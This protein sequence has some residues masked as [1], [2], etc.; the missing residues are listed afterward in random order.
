MKLKTSIIAVILPVCISIF[1][2]CDHTLGYTLDVDDID[3]KYRVSVIQSENGSIR[4]V[5]AEGIAGTAITLAINP[6]P[7]YVLKVGSLAGYEL[8]TDRALPTEPVYRFNLNADIRVH[9]EFVEA[10]ANNFT[11]SVDETI[12]NGVIIAYAI[13]SDMVGADALQ[14]PSGRVNTKITLKIL[15]EP[16][17]FLRA[18]TLK[19]TQHN[20]GSVHDIP[21]PD[22]FLLPASNITVTAEFETQNNAGF[23]I[24]KGKDALLRDDYDSAVNAFELAYKADPKDNEAIF[25]STLGSL[26]SIAVDIK[27]RRTMEEIGFSNYPVNLNNLFTLG[28]AWQGAWDDDAGGGAGGYRYW[29]RWLDDYYG[30][31]LPD[32]NTALYGYYSF[33]NQNELIQFLPVNGVKTMAYFQMI[34]FFNLMNNHITSLNDVVDDVLKYGLGDAFEAA[35]S[36]A[37]N[38]EYGE[39]ITLDAGI[40]E[41][42]L[43][44]K[45]LEDGDP[46]GRAELDII[47]SFFRSVKS[48]FEWLSAYNLDMDRYIFRLWSHNAMPYGTVF[49]HFDGLYHE[50]NKPYYDDGKL[51]EFGEEQEDPRVIAN[52]IL[53]FVLVEMDKRFEEHPEESV[54]IPDMLPLRNPF[55]KERS[56]ARGMLNKSKAGLVKASAALAKACEY[57]YASKPADI[58]QRAKDALPKYEWAEDALGQ[59]QAALNGGTSFYFPEALPD[60]GTAWNYEVA[61]KYG[62]NMGKLFTPGQIGLDKLIV[63]DSGGR[64]PQFYGWKDDNTAVPGTAIGKVENFAAYKYTGLKLNL[65]PLKE[66][67]IKGLEKDGAL[68]NDTE[69]VHTFFPSL[70]FYENIPSADTQKP[71]GIGKMIYTFYY[72]LYNYNHM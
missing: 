43:L 49:P 60:S 44:G 42:L 55:L 39:T 1:L 26:A 33:Q 4:A 28:D 19:Y 20:D 69:Y 11:V 18:G 32:L 62:I 13:G 2:S 66:V 24:A 5:P 61:G 10:R 58:P 8:D 67:L 35:A 47:F 14:F 7:G 48:A 12:K 29:P 17:Y 36:R 52:N 46:A 57:Y 27:V 68:V 6:K 53:S 59:L 54:R 34:L 9:A 22:E 45:Y 25:Y 23:L 56:G 3:M 41:K 63:T 72:D 64:R 38:L 37:A 21:D 40:A 65:K 71:Y 31:M 70:L 50:L 16:G 30:I 51:N 15:T